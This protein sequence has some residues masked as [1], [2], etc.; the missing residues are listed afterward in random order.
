MVHYDQLLF[1][2]HRPFVRRYN[3]DL[4]GIELVFPAS[5]QYRGWENSEPSTTQLSTSQRISL[6]SQG[7]RDGKG[8][9][10]ILQASH[11]KL[12][13]FMWY[14]CHAYGTANLLPIS[15]KTQP[16]TF[17][18]W[19]C[20][21]FYSFVIPEPFIFVQGTCGWNSFVPYSAIL[22]HIVL[23]SPCLGHFL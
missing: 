23:H 21:G 19:C 10:M 22:L 18:R 1:L 6:K 15:P 12:F 2:S 9:K 17:P 16:K 4:C 20:L 8:E 11:K 7:W 3:P 5:S 13:L 14:A